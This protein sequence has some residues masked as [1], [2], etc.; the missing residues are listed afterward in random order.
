MR[1]PLVSAGDAGVELGIN[2]HLAAYSMI[3]GGGGRV[4]VGPFVNLSSQVRCYTV[5]DD[6]RGD[7]LA[8]PTVPEE[9]RNVQRGDVTLESCVLVGSGCLLLPGIILGE[10]SVV[11]AHTIVSKD[12]AAGAVVR[13]NPVREVGRRNV[14]VLRG[15]TRRYLE[16][17]GGSGSLDDVAGASR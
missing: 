2:V 11:G 16:S 3:F 10:G 12:V 9:Y 1:E 7:V 14:E 15:L 4:R 17:I 5:S 6:F 8:G 13:G